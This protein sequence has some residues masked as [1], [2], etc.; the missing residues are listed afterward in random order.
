MKQQIVGHM[1]EWQKHKYQR[2]ESVIF[3]F[4]WAAR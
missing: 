1:K 3:F 2:Y 4:V